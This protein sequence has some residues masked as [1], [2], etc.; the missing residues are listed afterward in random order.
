[1][2][3]SHIGRVDAHF[4]SI[5]LGNVPLISLLKEKFP[6]IEKCEIYLY[7]EPEHKLY[8]FIKSNYVKIPN[9][10]GLSLNREIILTYNNA[11]NKFLFKGEIYSPKEFERVL[12]MLIFA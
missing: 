7:P 6:E 4:D 5:L 3:C 9:R 12:N 2:L 1:M 8:S 10:R 11:D